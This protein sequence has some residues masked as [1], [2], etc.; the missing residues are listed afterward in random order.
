MSSILRA[1]RRAATLSVTLW[2][3]GCVEAPE[4]PALPDIGAV[5]GAA[6]DGAPAI[7][8][9]APDATPDMDR[10]LAPDVM[11]DVIPDAMPDVIQGAMPDVIQ[12]AMP[13]AADHGAPDGDVSTEA[14]PCEPLDEQC[15]GLD[16]DCDGAID[17]DLADGPPCDTGL[18]G[19]CADGVTVCVD[20]EPR[21]APPASDELCNDV[22]D[23]CDG[24]TDE[25]PAT[26][27][28]FPGS[29]RPIAQGRAVCLAGGCQLACNG[30]RYD[31]DQQP[32]N[33][34][35]YACDFAGPVEQCN[36]AD[37]D[38]NG[39]VD[40]GLEPPPA[41]RPFG[42]CS[43]AV[44][45]CDGRWREPEYRDFAHYEPDEVSCDGLDNDCDR[46]IDEG[47]C[48]EIRCAADTVGPPC[49]GCPEGTVIPAG[50]N[51][52]EWVCVPP[53]EFDMGCRPEE[54]WC[55]A[56]ER[57]AFPVAIPNPLVVQRHPVTRRQ[58]Q[59]AF[60]DAPNDP[61]CARCPVDNVTWFDAVSYVNQ[62]SRDAGLAPCYALSSCGPRSP[63]EKGL[64][65]DSDID[66][67]PGCTGFRLP[68]E[69]EREHFTRSGTRTR[70]WSGDRRA[71]LDAVGWYGANADGPR[72]VC[73]PP[74][75]EPTHPL[76]MC[77]VHGGINDWTET[78]FGAY[79]DQVGDG[80]R[81]V[82]PRG[83]AEGLERALRG[84]YHGSVFESVH[85][86]ARGPQPPTFAA[87]GTG[88]RPVRTA[89]IDDV[90]PIA[91]APGTH[92]LDGAAANGCE[93]VC[94]PGPDGIERCNGVDDDCDGE[95]DE[96]LVAPLAD[97][98]AG[99]CAGALRV[100]EDGWVEPDY[101]GIGGYEVEEASCDGLD[102]DCDGRVDGA[103]DDIDGCVE[104]RCAAR[105]EG[106]P[107]NGCPAGTVIPGTRV[108]GDWVCVPA[109]DFDFGC[110]PAEEW[111]APDEGPPVPVTLSRPLLVGVH[112]V[113]EG[114]WAQVFEIDPRAPGCI[115][116]PAGDVS[117]Y[118]AA[119][120]ANYLSDAERLTRCYPLSGCRA[121][122][123]PGAE[124]C[125]FDVR[126]ADDC[127][128]YRLPTEVEQAWLMGAGAGTRFWSGDDVG[129]AGQVA[130]HA[131]AAGGPDPGL[132]PVCGLPGPP[133]H[134]WGLCDAQGNVWEWSESWYG[135]FPRALGDGIRLIDPDLGQV[136]VD[137]QSERVLRGGSYRTPLVWPGRPDTA[138][139][140][141]DSR[142]AGH[143][144]TTTDSVGFRI[145]RPV[146]D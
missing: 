140:H 15:N 8:D 85:G 146:P 124:V 27:S 95:I 51:G 30:G 5:D 76:G 96:A 109:G 100:C 43:G 110:D 65:C 116:C 45:V 33:G 86:T 20:G 80:Q 113:T 39:L 144:D 58:W 90:C 71:D 26:A 111:C 6:A 42:V 107:C 104:I 121:H 28:C 22:D 88:F 63:A 29:P 4:L 72:P 123:P 128:G 114:D 35:E 84:G 142:A 13:D 81:Q 82:D 143:P 106:P 25:E 112:P 31:I 21:C 16:D 48:P 47:D 7:A 134:P 132:R 130:W 54:V 141:V 70:F 119:R 18:D 83:P 101:A 87:D 125:D 11:P 118:D 91:C 34:C 79:A 139:Q 19:R 60:L 126:R 67:I 40:D 36:G 103:D 1:A 117:W 74:E 9:A 14:G 99:V 92:D 78:R 136:D 10:D 55:E 62:L 97:R 50:P 75:P 38:C 32:E 138:G 77:D 120:Y 57:P 68:T 66:R 135:P 52:G 105:T 93:Y 89:C 129:V 41:D 137:A 108:P 98:Q 115:G 53:G 61:P 23:D 56:D 2:M 12:D 145:V 131:E 133:A 17:E 94:V 102:N 49:N 3:A 73:E 64:S 44:K 46:R 69:A 37:D 127:T 24:T 122:E 59:E